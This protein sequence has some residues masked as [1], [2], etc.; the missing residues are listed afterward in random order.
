MCVC[1]D[2]YALKGNACAEVEAP[3]EADAGPEQQ[4][5]NADDGGRR[6][7]TG[8]K[9]PC[10]SDANCAGFDATYCNLL[11]GQC[12]MQGCTE[13]GCDPGYMCIDLGMYIP[14]EPEVCLDPADFPQ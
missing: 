12:Q 2:G 13:T 6:P 10:T 4:G 11:V 5:N 1:T 7:Y 14:G 3:H 9:E 8:Q